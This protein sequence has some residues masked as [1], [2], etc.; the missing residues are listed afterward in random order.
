MRQNT[1]GAVGAAPRATKLAR[2]G[3]VRVRAAAA[4][5]RATAAASARYERFPYVPADPA[6]ARRALRPRSTTSRCRGWHSACALTG[7]EKAR[8]RRL[9]R[10]RL[11][12]GAARLRAGDGPARPAAHATSSPTRCRA[13]P[14]ATRT[15]EQ[16][17][18]ADARR[19]AARA[20]EIDIRPSC[21]QMLK[22]IGHPYAEGRAGLRRH[23]RERAGRRAHQPPVPPGQPPRRPRGRHRRPLA[24]WRSAGAPTASATTCRTTT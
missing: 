16:A 9:R 13:S 20:E 19:S 15:L 23:L 4:A 11:D 6:H 10:A 14:P 2:F 21:L 24:S 3:R 7:I 12:P 5:R 1:F 17:H 8:D 22:D 18:A